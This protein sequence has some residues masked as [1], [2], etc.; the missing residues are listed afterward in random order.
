MD[1]RAVI[2]Q[3]K[4]GNYPSNWRIYQGRGNYGCVSV[5]WILGIL[6]FVGGVVWTVENVVLA[7]RDIGLSLYSLLYNGIPPTICSAICIIVAH[8]S[9]KKADAIG[10]SLLVLLPEGVVQCYADDLENI[11]WLYYPGIDR[12]E[13]AQKTEISG[14]EDGVNSQTYYWLDMY[15]SDGAYF[16]L[17]IRDCFGDTAFLSKTIIA[18]YN[19]YRQGGTLAL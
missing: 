9:R 11:S 16:N 17:Q 7:W 4:Q 8:V 14:N 19:H 2:T 15:G 3:V 5:G 6:I 1:A 12:L 18:A 13:L 10:C